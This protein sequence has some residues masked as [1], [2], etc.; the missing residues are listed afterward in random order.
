[1]HMGILRSKT[2][3]DSAVK[4]NVSKARHTFYSL[5]PSGLHGENGLDPD[6]SIYLMQTYVMPVLVYGL[7]VV[8]PKQKHLDTLERFN[9]KFLKLILSLPVNVADP[10]VYILT[11]TLPVEAVLHKQ[12]LTLFGKI[13]RLPQTSI[14]RQLADRQS[15]GSHSWFIAVKE[16]FIKY[17]LQDPRRLLEDPPSKHKWKRIV[18]TQVNVYWEERIKASAVLYSSLRFLNVNNLKSG[19]RHPLITSMGNIREVPCI[20]TKLK[21][22]TSTYILQVNRAS[23]NQNQVNPMCLL[24]HQGDETVE[25]FLLKCPALT[26]IR[27][28]IMDSIIFISDGAYPLT[29]NSHSSLQLI[30]DCSFLTNNMNNPKSEQ[31][32]NLETHS[33][34]LCHALHCERYKLLALVPKHRRTRTVKKWVLG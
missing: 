10:A 26:G 13:C 12:V 21:L 6:T 8:L 15:Y 7:E 20:R 11:G 24:C 1:M 5:M 28:P 2:T 34:R 18:N 32:Q 9:R 30:L 33:R 19:M 27:N 14:E 16:I 17:N 31:L 25:H 29:S 3:E 23:F 22:V 4:E